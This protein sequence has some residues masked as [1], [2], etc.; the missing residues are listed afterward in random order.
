M[1]EFKPPDW[2]YFRVSWGVIVLGLGLITMSRSEVFGYALVICGLVLLVFSLLPTFRS[3]FTYRSI[4][5]YG[6]AFHIEQVSAW[7]AEILLMCFTY[8]PKN[9][10]ENPIAK[11]LGVEFTC[12]RGGKALFPWLDARIPTTPEPSALNPLPEI[13][14]DLGLDRWKEVILV[15]KK[16]ESDDCFLFNNSSYNIPDRQN[17]EWKLGPGVHKVVARVTGLK[18]PEWFECIFRNPGKGKSL[19][20]KSFKPLPLSPPQAVPPKTT[21]S[22]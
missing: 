17:P 4:Y 2:S 1:R 3:F 6:P 5:L 9:R 15:L 18:E 12:T 13:V 11:G 16:H 14:F 8:A 10:A 19:E 7:N 20:V 21:A 22:A